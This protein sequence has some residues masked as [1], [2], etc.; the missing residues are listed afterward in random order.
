MITSRAG[1]ETGGTVKVTGEATVNAPPDRV[2]AALRDPAVLARTIPGCQDLAVTGPGTC[3]LTVTAAVAAATGTYTGEAKLISHES[4]SLTVTAHLAGAPGTIETTIHARLTETGDG[5][6]VS[7]AA[8]AEATGMIAAIGRR[9]LTTAA[10]RLAVQFFAELNAELAHPGPGRSTAG[11]AGVSSPVPTPQRSFEGRAAH[12]G[13][14]RFPA[15]AAGVS[16]PVPTPQRSFEGRAAYQGPGRSP[17]GAAGVSSATAPPTRGASGDTTEPHS[18]PSQ[19]AG[20]PG[21][22]PAPPAAARPFAT[23]VLTGAALTLAGVILAR[24]RTRP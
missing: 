13:P 6:N 3:R 8:D 19:P 24:R 2:R 15:G 9:L 12:P 11:A 20:R 17:A 16:S 5:T 7:Y 1:A 18:V 4:Q 23:G 22:A 21:T 10:T 14:G